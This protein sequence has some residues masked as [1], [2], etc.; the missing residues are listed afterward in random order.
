[1]CYCHCIHENYYGECARR[2]PCIEDEDTAERMGWSRARPE[3]ARIEY[4]AE[5]GEDDDYE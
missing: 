2:G 3:Q 1:M 5:H 4:D